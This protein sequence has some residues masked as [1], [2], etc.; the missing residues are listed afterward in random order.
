MRTRL[1]SRHEDFDT[2]LPKVSWE[3]GTPSILGTTPGPK[4]QYVTLRLILTGVR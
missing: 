2:D 3:P 1:L 4:H